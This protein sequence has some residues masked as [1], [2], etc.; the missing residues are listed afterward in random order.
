MNKTPIAYNYLYA[1]EH[2]NS[3]YIFSPDYD[4]PPLHPH[5]IVAFEKNAQ[6]D[7]VWNSDDH[8]LANFIIKNLFHGM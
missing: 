4:P 5:W 8:S 3:E 6:Q 7:I 2:V 1:Q